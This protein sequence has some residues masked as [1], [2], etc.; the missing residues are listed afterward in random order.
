MVPVAA[1]RSG[2]RLFLLGLAALYWELAL[3]R[4]LGSCVRVI[5]YYSNFVLI[6]AFFGLGTGALLATRRVRLHRLVVPALCVPLLLGLYFG[7]FFH[8]NPEVPTNISGS[9]RPWAWCSRIQP[10]ARPA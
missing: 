4:W 9:A 2:W 5:A 8:S 7:R 6:A 1:T 10:P 3:I